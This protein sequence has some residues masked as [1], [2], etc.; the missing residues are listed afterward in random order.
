MI[1]IA[2]G[3]GVCSLRRIESP[4]LFPDGVGIPGVERSLRK[5]H[6]A[7]ACSP[8]GAERSVVIRSVRFC[9]Q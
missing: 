5:G 7:N 3:I 1:A 2:I 6:H 8:I 4:V 9:S